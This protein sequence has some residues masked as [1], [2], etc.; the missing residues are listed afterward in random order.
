MHIFGQGFCNVN[1]ANWLQPEIGT[2]SWIH[3][4]V[5]S[6]LTQECARLKLSCFFFYD[7]LNEEDFYVGERYA[8]KCSQIYTKLHSAVSTRT[9]VVR[10]YVL[11][12]DPPPNGMTMT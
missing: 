7:T 1:E 11:M 2:G 4:A 5:R 10:G 9:R 6:D 8:R 3:F 12:N